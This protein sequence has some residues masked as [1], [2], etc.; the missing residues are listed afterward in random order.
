[1]DRRLFLRA[2]LLASAAA[3]NPMTVSD[4]GVPGPGSP[5]G[6][7]DERAGPARPPSP[8]PEPTTSAGTSPP[9]AAE[10][11]PQLDQEPQPEPSP[12]AATAATAL[13]V[14]CRDA[15]GAA[16]PG[17][18]FV[19]HTIRRL[20]LHH[21]AV[22]L[23]DNRKAP[24][25]L[26]QH[27]RHHQSQGWPDIA[28]HLGVDRNGHLYDLRPAAFRGDTFTAYDPTGHF[29][30]LAEGNFDQERPSDA[31]LE[32][33]AAAFAWAAGEFGAGADTLTG[34][35]DH[36]GTSCPGDHLYAAMGP[37][38]QRIGELAA[39]GVIRDDRCGPEASATVRE[40][41]A[42]RA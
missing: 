27:Q 40:I 30:V 10:E 34:H 29:L 2:A 9:A 37:L 35:R 5:S 28:Y 12:S 26:R 1:M 41:E 36:A 4:S 6:P 14:L 42:G 25:R 17:E 7:S 33:V 24:G 20:T 8:R 38:R 16:P 13:T 22:V 21:S 3:C 11:P 19:A 18:G 15:W 31:Q 39:T 23:G 32:G